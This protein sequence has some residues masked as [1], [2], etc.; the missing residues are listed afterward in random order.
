MPPTRL[1]SAIVR[2][3]TEQW[4]KKRLGP[5]FLKDEGRRMK[6]DLK[7]EVKTRQAL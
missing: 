2:H 1:Q 4:G 6:D 5:P 3:L 7:D